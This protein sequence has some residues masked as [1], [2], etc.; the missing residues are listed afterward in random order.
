M[1]KYL[2]YTCS[3]TGIVSVFFELSFCNLSPSRPHHASIFM[4]YKEA[5]GGGA[6]ILTWYT[7]TMCLTFGALFSFKNGILMG[8]KLGKKLVKNK[9][10]FRGPA[11]TSTYDFGEI[12]TPGKVPPPSEDH[13]FQYFGQ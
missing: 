3:I 2:S 9:S 7:Y 5:R 10:D 6:L 12:V 11:A 13:A 1:L 8:G 4:W